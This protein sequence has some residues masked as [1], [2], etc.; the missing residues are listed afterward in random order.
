MEERL[1]K[2]FDFASESTKQLIALST[3]VIALTI[4]FSKDIARAD[5]AEKIAPHTKWVL[6]IA[7]AVYLLSILFGVLALLNLTGNLEPKQKAP[8]VPAPTIWAPGVRRFSVAQ[9]LMFLTATGLVII[10]GFMS[11]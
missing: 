4:T 3:G 11:L 7:W 10:F 5:A 6:F 8:P 9:I 2:A 1:K